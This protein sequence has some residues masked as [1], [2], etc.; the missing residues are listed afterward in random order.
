MQ[1]MQYITKY[2]L[3]IN[4]GTITEDI[5]K[6]EIYKESPKFYYV[7]YHQPNKIHKLED[8]D[9]IAYSAWNRYDG[10]LSSWI[11]L[12]DETL[13][14]EYRNKILNGYKNGL[15]N[16]KSAIMLNLEAIINFN[17]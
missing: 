13:I 2:T 15:I 16:H 8:I 7:K 14:A 3:T 11:Y 6:L 5:Q 4:K 1:D 9:V 10:S 17:K 12:L